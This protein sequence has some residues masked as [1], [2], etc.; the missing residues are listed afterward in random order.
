MTSGLIALFVPVS[1]A[2]FFAM[3]QLHIQYEREGC[4]WC[5]FVAGLIGIGGPL[6]TY[7]FLS[8]LTAPLP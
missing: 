6:A 8:S 3:M 1:W 4:G 5:G 7:A 2:A